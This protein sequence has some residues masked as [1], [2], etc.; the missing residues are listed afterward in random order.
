[1][2]F[3]G[4]NG[5]RSLLALA[6]LALVAGLGVVALRT[7]IVT[8]D[9]RGSLDFIVVGPPVAEI[10]IALGITILGILLVHALLLRVPSLEESDAI[11]FGTYLPG[12][13]PRMATATV[14][15]GLESR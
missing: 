9:V 2:R 11:R 13:S 4:A 3:Q 12:E 1:M 10:A 7:T 15:I 6:P 14:R 8:R 5:W